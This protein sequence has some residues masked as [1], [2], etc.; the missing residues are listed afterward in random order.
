MKKIALISSIFK[1][2][3][4]DAIGGIEVWAAY[5]IQELVKNGYVIDLFALPKSIKSKK[6]NL[7]VIAN[8]SRV[9]IDRLKIKIFK[10]RDEI[11]R[12][13]TALYSRILPILV[14][15]NYDLIIDSSGQINFSLNSDCIKKP[16]IVIGH[17]PVNNL[18]TDIY[19]YFPQGEK[20]Y[21]VFPSKYQK[22]RAD[23]LKNKTV[24]PHGIP[25]EN[26][27][28]S[29]LN[30]KES[31]FWVGRAPSHDPKGLILA[32][33]VFNKLKFPLKVYA[34]IE[35][36]NFLKKSI[37]P[38]IK[39]NISITNT[40]KT[41]LNKFKTPGEHKLLI[42]PLQWEEP[43]GFVLLE[44]M[45]CGTPVIAFAKGAVPEIIK[46][47][48]TGFIVNASDSDIRGNWIVKKTGIAGLCEAVKKIYLMPESK[49]KKMRQECRI[50]SE[51]TFSLNQMFNQYKKL[52][53]KILK[54]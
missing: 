43:F 40:F 19:K 30:A 6:V 54:K 20:I 2:T 11:E 48:K 17:Y 3:Q 50:Y 52:F 34:A 29:E 39:S 53:I 4:L 1:P 35:D 23:W 25:I 31:S 33:K 46:D 18:Y 24:I 49:Y 16:I 14:Y 36:N 7:F 22:E 37:K 15:N 47:G 44:S 10:K 5:F 42:Y 8:I 27:H 21:F 12:I 41:N 45:A 38:C 26:F 28:F 32:L 9:L 51:N 13:I